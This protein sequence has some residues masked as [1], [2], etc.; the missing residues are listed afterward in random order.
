MK[1]SMGQKRNACEV[2]VGNPHGKKN[3]CLGG[4]MMLQHFRN[5]KGEK[6]WLMAR[7]IS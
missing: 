5:E 1:Q 2:L 3:V 4:R 6:V 7:T